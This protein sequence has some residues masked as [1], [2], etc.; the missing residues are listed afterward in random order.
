MQEKKETKSNVIFRGTATSNKTRIESNKSLPSFD[1]E[2]GKTCTW[3]VPNIVTVS[4]SKNDAKNELHK[5]FLPSEVLVL[6]LM[7]LTPEQIKSL[8]IPN[9]YEDADLNKHISE[10][11]YDIVI[12][13]LT[14]TNSAKLNSAITKEMVM[15]FLTNMFNLPN[16]TSYNS[17]PT[18][19]DKATLFAN[20]IKQDANYFT[21]YYNMVFVPY[22][23]NFKSLRVDIFNWS[24]PTCSISINGTFSSG[25]IINDKENRSNTYMFKIMSEVDQ[26]IAWLDYISINTN[27]G[28]RT[29]KNFRNLYDNQEYADARRN[30]FTWCATPK[31]NRIR[32][33]APKETVALFGY[34]V[35]TNTQFTDFINNNWKL[36]HY[37]CK[38]S[39][40]QR[41]VYYNFNNKR[42]Q[43]AGT[44]DLDYS[45]VCVNYDGKDK[46][47]AKKNIQF[48][49]PTTALYDNS[50]TKLNRNLMKKLI[51]KLNNDNDFNSVSQFRNIINVD[52][53]L[54]KFVD[55][56]VGEKKLDSE[57][58]TQDLYEE[59]AERLDKLG[60]VC[61]YTPSSE[62]VT[63]DLMDKFQQG[64][65][66]DGQ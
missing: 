36:G 38:Y 7:G 5:D 9:I 11:L 35:E 61:K 16:N 62:D 24:A 29:M 6:E 58:F 39:V 43:G 46:A 42:T 12:Y 32:V 44:L 28:L 1:I 2:V 13:A 10:M 56:V 33:G 14:G 48:N 27:S 26:L 53:E 17:L 66:V 31:S 23:E 51:I 40:D 20:N 3:A 21:T 65:L 57:Y 19:E 54:E 63:K 34:Q 49:S 18:L 41:S 64:G 22:I 25:I 52:L 60:I 55:F 4:G 45:L 47:D 50:Y 8:E 15:T 37:I 30:F 59:Y